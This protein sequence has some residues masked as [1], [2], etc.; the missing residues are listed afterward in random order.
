[1][2][3]VFLGPLQPVTSRV[4][5]SI[6]V[7]ILPQV[8]HIQDTNTVAHPALGPGPFSLERLNIRADI[9]S[10]YGFSR[11]SCGYDKSLS[12]LAERVA[13]QN[14]LGQARVYGQIGHNFA[15]IGQLTV[16]R[17]VWQVRAITALSRAQRQSTH[18]F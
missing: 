6:L 17:I 14:Q 2:N 7:H 18:F 3:H 12:K 16:I 5:C 9:P 13:Q 8:I 4:E 10:E 1:L 15:H 11:V